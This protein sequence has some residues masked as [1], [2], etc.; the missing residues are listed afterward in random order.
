MACT[1]TLV[2]HGSR[3]R[4]RYGRSGAAPT[5]HVSSCLPLSLAAQ[6]RHFATLGDMVG[7]TCAHEATACQELGLEYAAVA[8]IDNYCNGIKDKLTFEAFK[9]QQ[10]R[11]GVMGL[12]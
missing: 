10:V 7:M 4:L 11:Q 2:A 6:I 3:P 12:G 1:S 8:I 9:A 5:A